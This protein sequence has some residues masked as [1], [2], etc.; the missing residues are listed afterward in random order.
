[1]FMAQAGTI[2]IMAV[3]QQLTLLAESEA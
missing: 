2:G 3:D 1:M